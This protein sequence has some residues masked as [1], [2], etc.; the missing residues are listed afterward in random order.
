MLAEDDLVEVLKFGERSRDIAV[1]TIM[2][3]VEHDEELHL[4]GEVVGEAVD[5]VVVG[6]C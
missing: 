5:E 4:V 1:Q 6:E 2:R 3:E